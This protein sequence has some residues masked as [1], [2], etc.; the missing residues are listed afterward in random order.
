V[1]RRLSV[2]DEGNGQER[3]DGSGQIGD[4]D[5]DHPGKDRAR[6]RL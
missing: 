3:D 1:Q 2:E 5:D 6:Q 4:E